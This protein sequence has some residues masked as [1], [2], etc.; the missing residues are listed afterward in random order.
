MK[1]FLGAV[2][3][4]LLLLA[5][6]K[7]SA[8][9]AAGDE[10]LQSY[11]MFQSFHNR[12]VSTAELDFFNFKLWGQGYSNTPHTQKEIRNQIDFINSVNLSYS[13]NINGGNPHGD[14]TLGTLTF[15]GDPDLEKKSGLLANLEIGLS[16]RL[17]YDEGRYLDYAASTTLASSIDGL[18]SI[19]SNKIGICSQNH[20]VAWW[21]VDVCLLRQEIQKEI[22]QE[23]IWRQSIA[24]SKISN[25]SDFYFAKYTFGYSLINN[26]IFEQDQYFAEIESIGFNGYGSRVRVTY[27]EAVPGE[28]AQKL[29]ID[30]TVSIN[31]DEAPLAIGL[32]YSE[33]EGGS[34]FGYDRNENSY[35]VSAS[36]PVRDN[37]VISIGYS[38]I[39]SSIDYFDNQS[40]TVNLQ[41]TKIN[42]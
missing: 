28:L 11:C 26:D 15:T 6:Q 39:D 38:V 5:P 8:C 10:R 36:Y 32:S 12:L 18:N 4:S 23:S 13:D 37:L 27:G 24:V 34:F 9:A 7:A 25:F 17:I 3:Y 14:L 31:I 2:G 30:G 20:I 1:K 19:T 16:G 41:F 40:P 42:M 22:T 33:A 35:S 21:Y 29:I